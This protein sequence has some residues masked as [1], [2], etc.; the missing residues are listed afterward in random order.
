MTSFV[1]GVWRQQEGLPIHRMETRQMAELDRL[2]DLPSEC[3]QGHVHHGGGELVPHAEN[4][5]VWLVDD[6]RC[7]GDGPIPSLN[8]DGPIPYAKEGK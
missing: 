8:R 7:T 3:S 5:S 4:S 2:K 1:V 6:P